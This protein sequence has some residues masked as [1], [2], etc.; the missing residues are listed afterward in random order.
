M[1]LIYK[2]ERFL[3]LN[4]DL[5]KFV[6][7][8]NNQS[9]SINLK[10]SGST[11][12]PKIITAL[13]KNLV[14]SASYTTNFLGLKERNSALCCLP[15]DFIAGKMMF[16]RAIQAKLDLYYTQPSLKPLENLKSEIDFCAMTPMQVENSLDKIH[17]VKKVIIGGAQISNSLAEKLKG[18]S[19]EIYETFG[20][21]ETFSHFALRKISQNNTDDFFTVFPEFQISIDERSCLKVKTPYYKNEL[22]TNDI[23]EIKENKFK[24]IGR[25][26]FIIN[27]GGIKLNPEQIENKLQKQ[28]RGEFIIS[29]LSDKVLGKKLILVVNQKQEKYNFDY[30]NLSKYEI[31]KEVYLIDSFEKTKTGKIIRQINKNNLKKIQ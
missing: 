25:A 20:M 17:L 23:V 13:K 16:I 29:S 18:F 3:N 7:E 21:T 26:D 9:D 1:Q 27:S 31:P 5:E 4:A 11:G 30:L 24:F 10:T 19:N 2:G 28:I 14:Q 8:W 6:S 15:I 12:S 22:Q